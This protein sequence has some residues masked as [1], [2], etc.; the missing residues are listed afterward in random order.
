MTTVLAASAF[1]AADYLVLGAYMASL[2]IVGLYYRRA[3]R[4]N[5][6]SYFLAERKMP[7]WLTGFSYA[8]TCLNTDSVVAYCGMTVICG[9]SICWWYISRFGLAL[10]IGAVLFAVFWRRLN[11][12]TSPEFY[13]Y[14]FSGSPAAIMRSWVSVRSAFIAVVAWTG[15]GLL[16]LHKVLNTIVGWEQWQ[17]YLVVVPVLLI[18]VF[19]SGY[20]G[21]V[22]TDFI[23]A[24]VIIGS[25]VALMGMVWHDFGGPGG[26]NAALVHQFGP[27]AVS[28]HPPAT[29]EYLGVVGIIAWTLGTAVGYGGDI[30]PMAGA[31]EGQR[32]L[33]CRNPREASKMYIWTEVVL[34]FLLA[35]VTLPALGAMCRWPGL[36]DGTIDKE[37]AYPLLLTHYMPA[38]LLG[39][40]VSGLA[41]AIMSTVSSNLNFGAQV[42]LS[43]VYRRFF[44]THAPETHYLNVGRGVMFIIMGL[45]LLVAT[46]AKNVIDVSVFMLGLASAEITANW[47][48]WWW[49]RFNGKARLAASFGGPVIFLINK[50]F[51]FRYVFA[52]ESDVGYAVILTSIALTTVLWIVVA[53]LTRPD[54]EERLIEFYQRVRPLGWWGPI[55]QKAGDRRPRSLPIAA[56]L[57]I[58]ALGAVMIAAGTIALSAGYVACWRNAILFTLI[59]VLAGLLFKG[60]FARFMRLLAAPDETPDLQAGPLTPPDNRGGNASNQTD[61]DAGTRRTH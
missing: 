32:L 61:T 12:F 37:L 29:H 59:C 54:P 13:E 38:G 36:A 4:K 9:V 28:W 3:A 60:S 16:G 20:V 43:D 6:E 14:R 27:S 58:A 39:L 44:V 50:C 21:V 2:L 41:A 7:G 11:I 19:M 26:L 8:A 51:V 15:S 24:L 45:A 31:M 23:Q 53:L 56:G 46:V 55:A 10:M 17:S 25:A 5:L 47:G 30:A 33:S 1:R 57:G 22:V 34:F 48:Q 35:V 42:I 18:Y 40:A 52:P 49:W